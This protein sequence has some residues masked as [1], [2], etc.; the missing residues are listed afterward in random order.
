QRLETAVAQV[1]ADRLGVA[2]DDVAVLHGDTAIVAAGVGTF[3]SRS[4]AVGAPALVASVDKVLDKARRI[5]AALLEAGADDI[6]VDRDRFVVRG[7][8]GAAAALAAGA[9]G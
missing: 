6:V 7:L 8:P 5:A 2:M 4:I 9:A 1:V 3:G